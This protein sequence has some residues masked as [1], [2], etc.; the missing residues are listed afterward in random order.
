MAKE[1]DIP[2]FRAGFPVFD[3]LGAQRIF[4][5]GYN[6]GINFVD[7]LTNTM[8]DYYYDGAGY[9]LKGQESEETIEDELYA[10]EEV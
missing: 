3:R 2:L 9:E 4:T 1:E 8:L 10:K 5:L 7:K 6:G